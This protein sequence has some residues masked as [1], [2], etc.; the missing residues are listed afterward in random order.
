MGIF[1]LFK[2]GYDS[3]SIL[4]NFPNFF[5]I[6]FP[7]APGRDRSESRHFLTCGVMKV[8]PSIF[9]FQD[10]LAALLSVPVWVYLGFWFGNN[11]EEAFE[12]AKQIQIC[13]IVGV[14]LFIVGY[15]L[16]RKKRKSLD[17]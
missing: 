10:G 8:R 2:D 12:V 17:S 15:V 13:L 4:E 9:L 16:F 14:I 3:Y 6:K 7:P 5:Y 11:I 1:L